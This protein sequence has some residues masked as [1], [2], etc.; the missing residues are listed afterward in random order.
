MLL[1]QGLSQAAILIDLVSHQKPR[2]HHDNVPILH[3]FLL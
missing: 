2:Q 1:V 3:K